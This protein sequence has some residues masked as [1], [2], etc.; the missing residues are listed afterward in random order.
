MPRSEPRNDLLERTGIISM[1]SPYCT[2]CKR[3]P[4]VSFMASRTACGMTTWNLGDN[5][6]ADM[7]A[8]AA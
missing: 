2:T 6:T 5:V 8:L 7:R 3:V 1:R 4:G